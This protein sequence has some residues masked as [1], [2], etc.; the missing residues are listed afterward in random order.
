MKKNTLVLASDHEASQGMRLDKFLF[1]RFPE[2]S[3]SYFQTL[4]EM[5]NV[6]INGTIVSKESYRLKASDKLSVT[7][8]TKS[9]N[10]QPAPVNFEIIDVQDDFVVI[11][12]PAGLIV[13][14]ASSSKETLSLVNGLLHTFK[15]LQ[16]FDDT[17]RPGIIHRLDKDTS[18]L[19]II[20]RNIQAQIELA[21]LFKNRHIQKTYLAV[22]ENRPPQ[23]GTI[24]FPIGRDPK[25]R[26]KM[27]HQGFAS[28]PA[29]T[30]YKL[31]A[32]Y[33]T[34]SLIQAQIITGRTHQIRVHCAAIGH[35]VLGDKTYGNPSTLID[36]QAL[37]AWKISFEFRGKKFDYLCSIPQDLKQALAQLSKQDK[38]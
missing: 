19:M 18:G 7:F 4:I 14:H 26:H 23:N 16:N 30:H 20:A 17:Q 13:H 34:A 1:A 38:Y 25:H 37:H 5:G 21:N 27:S 24:E 31:L 33:A 32:T 36:R 11:N 9:Y 6:V 29:T 15:E 8:E 2:Y 10:C 12:K 3:R 22:V 35:P 28:R